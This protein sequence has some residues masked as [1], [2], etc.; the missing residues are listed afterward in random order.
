MEVRKSLV[1]VSSIERHW[2]GLPE[3]SLETQSNAPVEGSC[4]EMDS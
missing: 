3:V 1:T 2:V 4:G